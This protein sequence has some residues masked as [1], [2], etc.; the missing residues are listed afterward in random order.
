MIELH[1]WQASDWPALYTWALPVWSR[2]GDDFTSRDLGC[3]VDAMAQRVGPLDRHWGVYRDGELGGWLAEAHV[4]P[5]VCQGHA[6]FKRSFFGRETT[7]RAIQ[8]GIEKSW[9]RGYRKVWMLVFSDNSAII[10]TI[11][12]DLGGVYEGTLLAQTQRDG[13][14]VNM[15]SFAILRR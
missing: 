6:L 9:Q 14:P 4:N 15:D 2:F 10:R 5:V 3:F 11:R 13:K 8:L 12:E 1:P 7:S